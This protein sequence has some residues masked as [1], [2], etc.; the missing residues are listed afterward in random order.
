MPGRLWRYSCFA[1]ATYKATRQ[2]RAGGETARSS[3]LKLN[4]SDGG[5]EAERSEDACAKPSAFAV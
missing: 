1:Q 4:L 3:S 5:S 2:R